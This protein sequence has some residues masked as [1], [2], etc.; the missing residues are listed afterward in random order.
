[1]ASVRACMIKPGLPVCSIK[2]M[3]KLS[4]G[5]LQGVWPKQLAYLHTVADVL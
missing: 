2:I 1:M 5:P 4:S 3:D